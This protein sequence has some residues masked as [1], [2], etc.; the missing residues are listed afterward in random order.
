[1]VQGHLSSP[2]SHDVVQTMHDLF[3]EWE[4]DVVEDADKQMWI[5]ARILVHEWV[6]NLV[7]HADFAGRTPAI[8]I[9]FVPEGDLLACIVQDNSRGFDLDAHLRGNLEQLRRRL[10]DRGM[11]LLMLYGATERLTYTRG[12]ADQSNTLHFWL[13]ARSAVRVEAA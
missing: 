9:R 2:E 1:M 6:A 10:P 3:D 8:T 12:T 4:C 13:A 7:Q 5:C 11:G